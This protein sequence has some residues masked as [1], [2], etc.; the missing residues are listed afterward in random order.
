MS[1]GSTLPQWFKVDLGSEYELH[2]MKIWNFNWTGYTDRGSKQVDVY[3][4]SQSN[5]PGNP[6]DDP[7]NWTLLDAAGIYNLTEATGVATYDTP[8]VIHFN[9]AQAQWIALLINS[10]YA[11][12]YSG[13][14]EVQFFEQVNC[15]LYG[16][17]NEDGTVNIL[18][19]NDLASWWLVD[20]C[21]EVGSWCDGGDINK[22]GKVDLFDFTIL[23][24]SWLTEYE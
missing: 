7:E 22:S 12:G 5:D 9:G 14:S 4:S 15:P 23:A 1:S 16:D 13:L 2:S 20:E 17:I 8:D 6:I 10:N 18:D 19:L 3:C 11:G 24:E 21:G